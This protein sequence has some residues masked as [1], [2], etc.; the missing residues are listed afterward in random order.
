MK[1]LKLH[2]T[3]KGQKVINLEYRNKMIGHR[4]LSYFKNK[5]FCL[6]YYLCLK[7]KYLWTLIFH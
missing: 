5:Q 3:T 6:F 1:I 7:H 4:N 2:S